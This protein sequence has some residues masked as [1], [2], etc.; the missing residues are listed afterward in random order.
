[1]MILVIF[2]LLF[3]LPTWM[4]F[5]GYAAFVVFCGVMLLLLLAWLVEA[6]EH[7]QRYRY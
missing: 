6:E 7:R 3:V 5:G 1:M 2:V 4:L